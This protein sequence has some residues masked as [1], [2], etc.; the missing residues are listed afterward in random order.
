MTTNIFEGRKF[1]V[2][3]DDNDNSDSKGWEESY[4]YCKEYIEQNNGTDN[5]YFGDYHNGV[6]SI[7]DVESGEIVYDERI[8]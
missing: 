4:E 6:V 8:K 3:F 7:V 1:D 2:C 5:S